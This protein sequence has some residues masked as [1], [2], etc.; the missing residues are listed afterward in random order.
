MA[1]HSSRF[2]G[3]VIAEVVAVGAVTAAVLLAG[4]VELAH[5]GF[6]P[7]G[8]QGVFLVSGSTK[9]RNY[10]FGLGAAARGP[11]DLLSLAAAAAAGPAS[12][13]S[14][15]LKTRNGPELLSSVDL[16]L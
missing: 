4:A 8:I 14:A 11:R 7:A 15:K 13:Q 2:G 5:F 9:P 1:F 16:S 3:V 10:L 6:G 12:S